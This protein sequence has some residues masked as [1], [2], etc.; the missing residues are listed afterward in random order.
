MAINNALNTATV[1]L[2]VSAGGLG[3]STVPANGQIPI[4]NGTNYVAA[5]ITAGA[6][7][8]ITDGAGSISISTAGGGVNWV[9]IAGT[10]QA[11]L[12][13]HGY[14]VENASL[15]T[16]TLPATAP[17]GSSIY[18]RGLG[19]AGFVVQANAGQVV[20]FG[21]SPTS[22]GGTVTSSGNFDT[23]DFTCIVADTVWS[24]CASQTSGMTIA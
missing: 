5:N 12:V 23:I 6:G 21:Q 24:V 14:V 18:I 2:P 11:A 4:G 19:A 16:I 8:T 20:N 15:T 3:V 22:I 17:I 7:I 13:N 1:P 9:G 10:T